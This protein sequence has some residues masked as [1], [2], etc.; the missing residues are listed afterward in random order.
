MEN[1]KASIARPA[2]SAD[3]G[4]VTTGIIDSRIDPRN[5]KITAITRAT[6]SAK[7]LST[8]SIELSM[9]TASSAVMSRLM[10]GGRVG[11]MRSSSALTA[12]EMATVLAWACG[13]MPIPRE[14][15]PLAR[16][17]DSRCSGPSSIR[18]T[19][20]RRRGRPV[21][22]GPP[23]SRITTWR[24]VSGLEKRVWARTCNC[25]APV[26]ISPAGSSTLLACKAAMM[27]PVVT[28]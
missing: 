3:M 22:F 28:P 20:P 6:A 19:S 17:M 1:P 25:R 15:T 27:S 12:L 11:R 4:M 26:S 18:A 5:R 9:N 16:K 13:W 2:P 10:P 8:C 24:K 21:A 7:T 14:I 23:S